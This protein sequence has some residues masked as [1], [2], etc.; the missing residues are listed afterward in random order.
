MMECRNVEMKECRNL[1][2][3]KWLNGTEC[4]ESTVQKEVN[5]SQDFKMTLD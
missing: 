5:W 3:V 1:G 2:M 4:I